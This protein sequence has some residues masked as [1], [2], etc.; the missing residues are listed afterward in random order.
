MQKTS[1]ACETAFD[2]SLADGTG[3]AYR[4]RHPYFF[5]T[6]SHFFSLLLTSSHFFSLLLTSSHFFSLSPFAFDPSG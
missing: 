5:L 3:D 6:S 2:P 1:V 4:K